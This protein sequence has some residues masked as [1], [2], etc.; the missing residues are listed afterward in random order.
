MMMTDINMNLQENI[1]RI[2][3][4]DTLDRYYNYIVNHLVKSTKIDAWSN[5]RTRR[6]DG[7]ISYPFFN[8]PS[9]IKHYRRDTSPLMFLP[10]MF[11]DYCQ[12][13]YGLERKETRIVWERYKEI[14][15]DKIEDILKRLSR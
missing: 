3:R 2:L 13:M 1:R 7:T 4:E 6:G 8:S 9:D 11:S 5:F 14:M 10:S 12:H 15:L